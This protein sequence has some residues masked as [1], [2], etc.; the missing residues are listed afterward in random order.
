M[1]NAP[2]TGRDSN[3]EGLRTLQV[4]EINGVPRFTP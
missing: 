1:Q 4:K 2:T 3:G